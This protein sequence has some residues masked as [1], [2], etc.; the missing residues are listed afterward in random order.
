MRMPE[1]HRP[2]NPAFTVRFPDATDVI[3]F[4]QFAVRGPDP[5]AVTASAREL[6]VLLPRHRPVGRPSLGRLALTPGTGT[7]DTCCA[8]REPQGFTF[9]QSISARL[10][11][12][13]QSD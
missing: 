10:F 7:L 5:E 6:D 9:S 4:A 3:V 8:W 12:V 13:S 1:G 11:E 2:S